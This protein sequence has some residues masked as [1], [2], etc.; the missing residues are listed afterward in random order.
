VPTDPREAPACIACSTPEGHAMK[1]P[2]FPRRGT[3]QGSKITRLEDRA[4]G[5][6]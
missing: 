4:V 3:L 6:L 1:K 2:E 5:S